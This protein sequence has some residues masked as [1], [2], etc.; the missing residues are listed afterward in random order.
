M[1]LEESARQL[2][3][4]VADMNRDRIIEI[5]GH[6]PFTNTS[7]PA[8]TADYLAA[9]CVYLADAAMNDDATT[10]RIMTAPENIDTVMIDRALQ[11]NDRIY[12]NRTELREAVHRGQAR[13]L[14]QTQ[15]A[16]RLHISG[17]T[18]RAHLAGLR[19]AS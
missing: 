16:R 19:D 6:E 1:T 5:L 15:I 3:L 14:T 7:A 13:G 9:L 17:D 4:A 12:L 11:G 2:M 10:A 18:T 8:G